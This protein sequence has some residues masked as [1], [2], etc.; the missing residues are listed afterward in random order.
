MG[1]RGDEREVYKQIND[2]RVSACGNTK[3]DE[4]EGMS[5]GVPLNETRQLCINRRLNKLV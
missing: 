2:K 1:E 3:T 5:A 4:Y